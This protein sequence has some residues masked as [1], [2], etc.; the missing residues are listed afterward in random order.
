MVP[1]CFEIFSDFLGYFEAYEVLSWIL[2][3]FVRFLKVQKRSMTF[4][5]DVRC[6]LG[7]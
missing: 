6:S 5:C 3:C 1:G 4:W 7:F 2:S